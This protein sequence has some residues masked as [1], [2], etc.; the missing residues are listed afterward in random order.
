MDNNSAQCDIDGSSHMV[1][2][3]KTGPIVSIEMPEYMNIAYSQNALNSRSVKI[4]EPHE[5][6]EF[7]SKENALSFYKEY[8]KSI[9]FSVIT[10]ASR[11]SRISG[12]FIDAKFA[13]TKYGI[14]KE[15]SS[16]VEVSDPVTN[17]NNGMGVAG[18]K[19]R[20]RIN[21]SWEKTD[22]KACMHVKR[23]QSGRW[24]IRS[25]IKEHNHEVFPNESHYFRGHGNLEV[26]SSN[27]DVLQGNRA[28]RKSKL[29]MKSRQ[30]GGC[31]IANKQKVAVTDQVYKLQ[32]LAIDEG[33]V[34]VMLDHF[35]CMQD[36][37]PNFFYSID[38][39][40]KQSLRNVLWVDAK[41]RL[42][43]A[44]FAD[45]VFFDT[46]F[47]KN[48]YRLPFAPFI[49]VNHHFQFVL[50][51]CSLVADET[52][53]T[54]AWLMRAWLRAMQKCS[55]KVILTVQDE[56]LKEA[57]AEELPDSCHC[58]C[59]WDIYGKIPERL[60]HVIRQDENFMLMFD[61]CVFRSWSIELFEKQWQT[62]VDRFELSH[63]SWFKSLYADRSRWI[64]AYMKNIF[65]AG[66]S[67][68]QRPEGINSF[69]DKYIQR[70]TSVRELLD[71][72]S[73]LIRDKFE[74]ERKADFETFH[75][76]P[77]LKSPSPFGKQM[78]AL[79]TQTVF[80]KFQVEVLGVVACH[81]KKESEDGVIKVFRVQDFEESQD[82]LVEWN[83]ATS[84]ISCLCRSFEFNGYLCRHV[85]IVLQISG[86]HSI[87][88]QYVLTRWT[89]KA[90]S[91]QKTRKG[92]NVESR[93]QR[94]INLYQQAF[95]LSDEGSLSHE[96][97]NVAFN[98]LE[99][100]SRKCE[101]L[102]GSIQP[103]P[104][105]HSS[106]ESEEVNQDK[107]TNKAHKKNTTTN[108]SRQGQSNSQTPALHCPDEHEGLQGAEQR[109]RRAPSLE[110]CFGDQQQLMHG[111]H[112]MEQF[113][114]ITSVT[115]SRFQ[116]QRME[117]HLNF[118]PNIVSNCFDLQVGP[119]DMNPSTAGSTKVHSISSKQFK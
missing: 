117:G 61:E 75:K 99:E 34:Q 21:R 118:R 109:S 28:R 93:V 15:S 87:P 62:L 80:K 103:S 67:T 50:L 116:V 29:C 24:A 60:S 6:M 25:F 51:G 110:S 37:N 32:H 58:Y 72:Y 112:G 74:E 57:I 113:N 5:G 119:R 73:T 31:T 3:D 71:R 1:E 97:Y 40:E 92:S 13:C 38:L 20:G 98:A 94:Y 27:T 79:Y 45:V 88:S 96:S 7:E 55:P 17:S 46:T 108:E 54:Y 49:G 100:A 70:K 104:V 91:I 56:A 42:D 41:G 65:L 12:K 76:Q 95:R 115:D 47:I 69:L 18:K 63:N 2:R 102:S 64:P 59:L 89:R 48:E 81:P 68:R 36:E 26:G 44:S 106:H 33:D 66:I 43:Y 8:A 10:K 22:C 84:D 101:S 52:K 4:I 39:N 86:I 114:S 30:S 35:V 19:K 78:A 23:L 105:V 111:M 90:K 85:M 9:G 53:S 82:F 107:K 14:K 77:A 16:V 83:E 11:R